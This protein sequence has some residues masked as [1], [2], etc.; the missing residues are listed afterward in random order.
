MRPT[1]AFTHLRLRAGARRVAVAV[2]VSFFLVPSVLLSLRIWAQAE[3]DI[4][5]ARRQQHGIAYAGAL[6]GLLYTLTSTESTVIRGAAPDVSTL[7]HAVG[8][9][10]ATGL[11][12]ADLPLARSWSALREGIG[13][14]GDSPARGAAAY[15][16]WSKAVEQSVLLLSAVSEDSGLLL[17]DAN[18]RYYLADVITRRLP[19]LLVAAGRMDD[20][21]FLAAATPNSAEARVR[22][23]TAQ[24]V[25]GQVAGEVAALLHQS[26]YL[27]QDGRLGRS[28]IASMDRV[29]ASVLA[30]TPIQDLAPGPRG[31]PDAEALSATRKRGASAVVAMSEAGLDGLWA[32][33]EDARGEARHSRA[34]AVGICVSGP[35][36]GLLVVLVSQLLVAPRGASSATGDGSGPRGRA[37]RRL[38]RR[39]AA[40]TAGDWPTH[41]SMQ[42]S[43]DV[44]P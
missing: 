9:V 8:A 43:A 19:L 38:K 37:H 1:Q 41:L 24:A 16:A 23:S 6:S 42:E 15:A 30:M 26:L 14:L 31:L 21:T 18:D 32:M 3:D 10:E 17:A 11:A 35:L 29:A 7:N 28:L 27:T 12:S 39:S 4:D 40:G 34:S 13:D 25:L 2:A 5:L 22:A 44:A 20:L 36:S 33:A